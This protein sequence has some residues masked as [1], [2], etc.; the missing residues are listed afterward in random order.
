MGYNPWAAAA[1][2]LVL[3]PVLLLPFFRVGLG[4]AGGDIPAV[5][6]WQVLLLLSGRMLVSHLGRD[7]QWSTPLHPVMVAFWG[8]ALAWSAMLSATHRPVVWRDRE[9]PTRPIEAP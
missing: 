6:V 3:T 9:V 1:V 8:L 4:V 7:P 2:V 5:A